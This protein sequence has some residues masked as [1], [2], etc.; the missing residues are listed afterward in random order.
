MSGDSGWDPARTGLCATC[1]NARTVNSRRG[2][3]FLLCVRARTDLRFD[4]YPRLP[5]RECDGYERAAP[6]APPPPPDPGESP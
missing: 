3:R 6:A 5:V 4:R 1:R 2:S